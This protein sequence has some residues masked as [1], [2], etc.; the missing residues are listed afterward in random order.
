MTLVITLKM[1]I[2]LMFIILHRQVGTLL[3]RIPNQITKFMTPKQGSMVQSLKRYCPCNIKTQQVSQQKHVGT[4]LV[5]LKL[6]DNK[7]KISQNSHW[8]V[9]LTK[10]K[11]ACGAKILIQS[12]VTSGISVNEALYN[13]IHLQNRA[14]EILTYER[15]VLVWLCTLVQ[16]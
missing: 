11:I 5:S 14:D 13:I 4:Y 10:L 3:F 7:G 15:Q 9:Q 12:Q 6:D 8:A 1:F 2:I 16:M